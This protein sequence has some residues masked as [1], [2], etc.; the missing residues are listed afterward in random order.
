M[1]SPALTLLGRGNSGSKEQKVQWSLCR[2]LMPSPEVIP[3]SLTPW[4]VARQLLCPWDLQEK[5]VNQ[6]SSLSPF[7]FTKL[8]IFFFSTFTSSHHL[9]P[10]LLSLADPDSWSHYWKCAFCLLLIFWNLPSLYGD[11]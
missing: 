10:F 4:T 5:E 7:S 8:F 11:T 6:P 1:V 2:L 9:Q 3:D